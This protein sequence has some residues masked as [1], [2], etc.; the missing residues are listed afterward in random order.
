[1]E[2]LL[3]T[4]FAMPK[5]FEGHIG[6]IQRNA[7][8]SWT[9]I[10]PRPEIILFGDEAGTA[11]VAN[12]L[13]LRHAPDVK[14]N[15]RGTPY[16]DDIFDQAQKLASYPAVC[17]VNADIILFDDFAASAA[18]VATWQPAYLMA[19]RRWDL[20][21][22]E[23]IDFSAS[24]WAERLRRDVAAR[25]KRRSVSWIDYFVF[26]RGMYRD[27]PPLLLGRVWWDNWLVWK[28]RE[29]GVPVVDSSPRVLAVHQNHEYAHPGGFF[30]I[31]RG[32]EGQW[33]ERLVNGGENARTLRDANYKLGRFGVRPNVE[34]AVERWWKSLA[35]RKKASP[36]DSAAPG[37]A[38][39]S[40]KT[41]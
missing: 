34:A 33:N 8:T 40:S 16:L 21:I 36:H 4:L 23:P 28:A 11:Q 7:I 29:L 17:Y 1:L 10:T 12:E 41:Q 37:A 19:G 18:A 32:E 14:R 39:S 30:G 20:D 3:L 25:S 6:V 5:P 26:A 9:R 2:T 35:K 27:V 38:A 22:T 13:S 31:W 24:S 15:D